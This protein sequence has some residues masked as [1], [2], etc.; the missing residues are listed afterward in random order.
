VKRVAMA[1]ADGS[2]GYTMKAIAAYFGMHH[3]IVSRAVRQAETDMTRIH[4]T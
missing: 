4:D 1:A 2:G 3:S